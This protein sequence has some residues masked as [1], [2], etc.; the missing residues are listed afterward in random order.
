MAA[1]ASLYRQN[2]D[3]WSAI[4]WCMPPARLTAWSASPRQTASAW[5]TLAPTIRAA[6][7]CMPAKTGLSSVPSP[8][9]GSASPV[10]PARRTASMYSG[11]WTSA[12]HLV[13]RGLRA[14][15]LDLVPLDQAEVAGQPPGHLQAQ[16]RH[17]VVRAEV[18]V[19][20]LGGPHDAH[21]HASRYPGAHPSGVPTR[22]RG[23]ARVVPATPPDRSEVTAREA[24]AS[25]ARRTRDRRPCGPPVARPAR[26]VDVRRGHRA[27]SRSCCCCRRR[28]PT[29]TAR[30][31]PTR[32][33]P[34]PRRSASPA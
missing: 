4:A 28:P 26:A 13:R 20:Q 18:V 27:S 23:R 19:Q 11:V 31:S 24:A 10:A 33:S 9:S 34:R 5:V 22:A 25:P 21:V 2:P 14:D 3:A 15:Q 1:A 32:C 6:A 30:R 12:E 8:W 17:R 7:S 16:R 29:G